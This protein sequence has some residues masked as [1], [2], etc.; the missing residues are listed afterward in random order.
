M[1]DWMLVY[2][3]ELRNKCELLPRSAGCEQENFKVL[4]NAIKN[5]ENLI[6]LGNNRTFI[7]L[8]YK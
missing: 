4:V 3:L 5:D 1:R 8:T 6:L 2:V 7:K